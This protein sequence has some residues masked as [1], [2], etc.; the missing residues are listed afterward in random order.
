[1]LGY[2]GTGNGVVEIDCDRILICP[3][4]GSD[5]LH[6]QRALLFGRSED[7]NGTIESFS[8]PDGDNERLANAPASMFPG[9]RQAV[10]IEFWCESCEDAGRWMLRI[11]QHKGSTFVEWV[12]S[13]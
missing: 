8:F 11:M 2:P 12:R 9:R 13:R 4:C 6:Q 1:M 10:L 3:S 5:N 7:A